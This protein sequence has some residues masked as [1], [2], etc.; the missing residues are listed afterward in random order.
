VSNTARKARKREQQARR[1]AGQQLVA[2]QHP[3]KV[4]TPAI[5]RASLFVKEQDPKTGVVKTHLNRRFFK[6]Y[7]LLL[8][9]DSQAARGS[10]SLV[11][12]SSRTPATRA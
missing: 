7:R 10:G 1:D 8:E 2:F 11:T 5:A 4:Y 9:N 6:R 3:R 12:G